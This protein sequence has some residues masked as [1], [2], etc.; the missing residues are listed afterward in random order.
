MNNVI[1]VT[2]QALIL[3][4]TSQGRAVPDT[5]FLLQFMQLSI[6]LKRTFKSLIIERHCHVNCHD[7]RLNDVLETFN[8]PLV[9]P[10][11]PPFSSTFKNDQ[12]HFF[13]YLCTKLLFPEMWQRTL[14]LLQL[15]YYGVVVSLAVI[16]L[17]YTQELI[18]LRSPKAK[19]GLSDC[20][21]PFY[22]MHKRLFN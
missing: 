19:L 8:L 22:K 5:N 12:H 17:N 13:T 18:T 2:Q 9:P 14:E 11:C 7:G 20:N 16:V 15:C 10:K 6:S 3:G 21:C 1:Q 4:I